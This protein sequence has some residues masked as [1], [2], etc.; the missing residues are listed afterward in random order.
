MQTTTLSNPALSDQAPAV[1]GASS[2]AS[3]LA[4]MLSRSAH[5]ADHDPA[6]FTLLSLLCTRFMPNVQIKDVLGTVPRNHHRG[7]GQRLLA[8]AMNLGFTVREHKFGLDR[9]RPWDCPALLLPAGGE[10]AF[11]LL[12][13]GTTITALDG[14]GK[15]RD[16]DSLPKGAIRKLQLEAAANPLSP[17]AASIPA[18]AGC[19]RW[20]APLARCAGSW[21]RPLWRW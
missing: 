19:A 6:F 5:G 10:E 11:L 9:L 16:L 14:E 21:W 18:I 7:T 17:K 1:S 3:A 13:E 2:K 4:T 15:E 20:S 12:S 8:A